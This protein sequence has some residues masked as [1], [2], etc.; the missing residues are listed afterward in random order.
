MLNKP[1]YVGAAILDLS[2]VHMYD[3]HYNFMKKTYGDRCQLLFT[4]TDSLT[5]H[6][7]TMDVTQDML[8]HKDMFD[9]ADYPKDHPLYDPSNKKVIGKF[10]DETSGKEILEFVG[11]KPK[12]Y[13]FTTQDDVSKKAKGVTKAVVKGLGF[14]DYKNTLLAQEVVVK[15]MNAIR[16]YRHEVFTVTMHKNVLSAYCNKLYWLEDGIHA[17]AYGHSCCKHS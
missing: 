6:I 5:Y 7:E 8:P 3:F 14:E 9:F 4:D 2:K 10:K 17:Y 11:L 13:A 15:P 16:S 12:M 1:V